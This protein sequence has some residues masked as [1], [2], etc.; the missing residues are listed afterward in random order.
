MKSSAPAICAAVVPRAPANA[1]DTAWEMLAGDSA[2]FSGP[3]AT[4]AN[5][6]PA[7]RA[8]PF[9]SAAASAGGTAGGTAGGRAG[10]TDGPAGGAFERPAV[11]VGGVGS[12]R[13]VE[14]QPATNAASEA[15][16]TIAI[17]LNA[18]VLSRVPHPYR[19]F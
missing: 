3:R 18:S 10:G 14:P 4:V 12:V 16:S 11:V 1:I 19:A 17:T 6:R 9:R 2:T 5:S 13:A 15:A 8:F 7:N